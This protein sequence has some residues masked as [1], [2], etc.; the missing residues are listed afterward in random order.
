MSHTPENL[1][2]LN[3]ALDRIVV[4]PASSHCWL[5]LMACTRRLSDKGI[6][7]Q[8]KDIL[9]SR[10]SDEGLPG[11]YRAMYLDLLT[12]E[13]RHINDAGRILLGLEPGDADRMAAYH[14]AA[15]QRALL[16]SNQREDFVQSLRNARLP[17]ISKLLGGTLVKL[18]PTLPVR[19]IIDR[20]RRVAL[21]SPCLLDPLHPPTLMALHQ[22][23]VLMKN[24][25]R[26]DL[27]SCQEE[28]V[29]EFSHL[30][31]NGMDNHHKVADLGDWLKAASPDTVVHLG[32]VRI[33]IARRWVEMHAAI[34]TFD[35]DLVLLVGL[36]SCLMEPLYKARPVLGLASNSVMPMSP[37]DVWL[38]A[39][40]ENQSTRLWPDLPESLAWHHPYRIKRKTDDVAGAPVDL[41][42]PKDAIILISV[43]SQLPSR[44]AGAWAERMTAMLESNPKSVW[45][46]VG[47][48]AQM[49]AALKGVDQRQLILIPYT[50]SVVAMLRRC[51]I[52]VNPPAMGGGFAVAEA[53]AEG[54]PVVTHADTDG[55]DKAGA[56]AVRTDDEYFER[57]HALLENG[58][59]R[60]DTGSRMRARFD[61]TL[62]LAKSGTSL[63]AACE[64][65]IGRFGERSNQASS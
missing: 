44:I 36:H 65:A 16:Y 19:R 20:L 13:A 22:A 15:L 24:G 7:D 38:C 57:L 61:Q 27:F 9:L 11:Y 32:D 25:I 41:D 1:L 48:E 2:L 34:A 43:G 21:V 12:G 51:D 33:S 58:E 28:V 40:L 59:L 49:P 54:L 56:D 60:L 42:V 45:V 5:N 63:M 50:S 14:Y 39:Q 17:E 62:D 30:L 23:E 46:L 3:D 8:V 64:E 53:M 37:T 18:R 55:G 52:Y 26:V 31:G 10:V 29:P 4:N 6:F 47:G 35:P